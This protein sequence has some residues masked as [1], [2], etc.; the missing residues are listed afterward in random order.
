MK[1]HLIRHT[2]VAVPEG[3]CYGRTEVPLAPGLEKVA[4]TLLPKLPGKFQLVTSPSLR[5]VALA[6]CLAPTYETETRLRELNFGAWE[7]RLWSAIPRAESEAWLE[8][9]VGRRPPGGESF[10][11]LAA[12]A[13]QALAEWRARTKES[14]LVCVTHGGI[15]RA[16]HCLTQGLPLSRAFEPV[17]DFGS[18]HV[19]ESE[20]MAFL[21]NADEKA[22]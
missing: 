3:L 12:R 18:L 15:I 14:A 1:I 13:T 7:N 22:R 6:K 19:F 9:F 10:G 11:E 8:D 16:L 4:T 20:Q 2:A 21:E 5:C 17:V